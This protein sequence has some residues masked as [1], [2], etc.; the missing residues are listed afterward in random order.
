MAVVNLDT[1]E[2]ENSCPPQ[3]RFLWS[4]AET[5]YFLK[6]LAEYQVTRHLEY[7]KYR[8]AGVFQALEGPMREAG[9]KRNFNQLRI[10]WKNMKK[11]FVEGRRLD[12]AG[13]LPYSACP[14]YDQLYGLLKNDPSVCQKSACGED[15]PTNFDIVDASTNFRDDLEE[16]HEESALDLFSNFS[17]TTEVN[18]KKEFLDLNELPCAEP[19]EP[20]QKLKCLQNADPDELFLA[21][22]LPDIKKLSAPKKRKVKMEVQRLLDDALTEE[23]Q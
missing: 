20:V 3:Q 1:T 5:E 14:F 17:K 2:M 19:S 11:T 21:M 9:Y 13:S 18:V 22:I 15:T 23:D 7:R 12:A 4:D 10:K 16:S 6:L 8:N